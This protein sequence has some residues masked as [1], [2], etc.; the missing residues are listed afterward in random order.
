MVY[1]CWIDKGSLLQHVSLCHDEGSS[2]EML[3]P[4]PAPL[5]MMNRSS[6]GLTIS[7]ESSN[8]SVQTEGDG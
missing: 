2:S 5:M 4:E 1:L 8:E 3:H 7:I 6:Q